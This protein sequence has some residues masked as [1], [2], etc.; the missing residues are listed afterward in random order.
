MSTQ[1]AP[2]VAL[3]HSPA[4]RNQ[5]LSF[6]TAGRAS[7]QRLN[8]LWPLV[9]IRPLGFEYN[10]RREMPSRLR[11]VPTETVFPAK[12]GRSVL[13]H[14]HVGLISSR[15]HTSWGR[16]SLRPARNPAGSDPT[17]REPL[18]QFLVVS[19]FLLMRFGAARIQAVSGGLE[20]TSSTRVARPSERTQVL[21]KSHGPPG[22]PQT[23]R[24]S[25]SRG[26]SDRSSHNSRRS[27]N[28][29]C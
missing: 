25:R 22:S 12:Q 2:T 10:P 17:T 5:S 20:M 6:K 13:P 21:Q 27:G 23:R 9:I 7:H 28:P 11:Q 18:S 4:L 29:F 24:G 16:P 19:S 8:F 15:D 26:R 14:L 1:R 3:V